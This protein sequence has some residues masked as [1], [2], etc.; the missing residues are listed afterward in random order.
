MPAAHGGKVLVRHFGGPAGTLWHVFLRTVSVGAA[1]VLGFSML[2]APTSAS[3]AGDPPV[4]TCRSNP[5]VLNTGFNPTTGGWLA[6]GS[7]DLNWEVTARQPSTSPFTSV[8]AP[9]PGL[10]WYPARVGNLV[11]GTWVSSPFGAANWISRESGTST[12]GDW[13]YRVRFEIDPSINISSFSLPMSFYADNAVAE[14]WVNGVAQSGLST[15]VPQ[16]NTSSTWYT[17]PGF[18]AG[19]QAAAVLDHSWQ[20]GLNEMVVLVKSGTPYEGFLAVVRPGYACSSVDLVKTASDLVDIDSNG[21]DPGDELSYS[22]A[23]TNTG[24]ETLNSIVIDDP[25]LGA[26]TVTCPQDTLEPEES[27]TCSS[28]TPLAITQADIDAGEVVNTAT[29][30][31]SPPAGEAVSD[32]DSVTTQLEQD[33]AIELVKSAAVDGPV[34]AGDAVSFNFVVTNAGNVT[35][36]EVAVEDPK[37]SEVNCPETALAPGAAM[38]CTGEYSVVEDDLVAGNVVNTATASG[39]PPVGEPVDASDS[40]TVPLTRALAGLI[41]EKSANPS[42]P[43]TEGDE[44]TFTFQVS[45]VGNVGVNDLTVTDP[46]VGAVT[47]PVTSLGV[48]ESTTCWAAPYEVTAADVAAGEIYNHAVVTGQSSAVNELMAEDDVTVETKSGAVGSVLAY[49]GS[50]V[51]AAVLWTAAG[52]LLLGGTL[53]LLAR[54]RRKP[55]A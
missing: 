3:A 7:S 15:G 19:Q 37:I 25:L 39:T 33:P 29:V 8:P 45:N 2:G 22:F 51:G 9:D 12:T 40:V 49:T 38:T 53:L 18:R 26:G 36:S 30:T 5:S 21:T 27:M 52:L 24:T 48:G 6:T 10:T 17:R 46:M 16:Y 28:D 23:V 1:A 32:D 54:R 4:L 43:V 34:S 55:I 20:T 14:V 50:T 42:G 31:A 35:L 44:I 13:Y 11:P 41:M 47:C